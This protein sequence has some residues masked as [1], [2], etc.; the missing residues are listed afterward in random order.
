MPAERI[1]FKHVRQHADFV[2]VLDAYGID[3]QKDGTKEG[4]FKCLCPFHEDS[5]PSM[6]VNTERNIFN[7]FP[8]DGGGNIL[9]FVMQMDDIAIRLA[10]KKVA[11]LSGCGYHA[12]GKSTARPKKSAPAAIAAKP[13]PA[14][15]PEAAAEEADLGF[16]PPLTFELQNLDTEHTFLEERGLTPEMVETYGLGIARRGMMKGRLVFPIHNPE[17]QLVAYCGRWIG[18]NPPDDEPKYKQPPRFRKEL[19]LYNLNRVANADETQSLVLVESFFSVVKMDTKY[20]VVSPMGR[21][22]SDEQIR[23]IK[24]GGFSDVVLLFDGDDPGRA[25][26]TTIGRQ[27]LAAG[28]SVKAPVVPEDFKPH[29]CDPQEIDLLLEDYVI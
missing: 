25:A 14:A 22:I 10:A 16:N 26:V 11:D 19:E 9:E 4:Q 12:G 8:C 5:K 6:K 15:K 23:L 27:L 2:A 28:L 17:W 18:D 13:R 29:R 1:D 21:S 7:C 20:N 24:N 3:L